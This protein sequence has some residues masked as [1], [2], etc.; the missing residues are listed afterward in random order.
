MPAGFEPAR[1]RNQDLLIR[2]RVFETGGTSDPA[3]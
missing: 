1:V 2:N 3:I